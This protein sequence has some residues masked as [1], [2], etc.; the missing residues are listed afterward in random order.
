MKEKNMKVL[1]DKLQATLKDV[2]HFINENPIEEVEV[3]KYLFQLSF[4]LMISR[5]RRKSGKCRRKGNFGILNGK[6]SKCHYH[7]KLWAYL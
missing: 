6:T 2:R 1:R 3:T 4:S 7:L 5:R